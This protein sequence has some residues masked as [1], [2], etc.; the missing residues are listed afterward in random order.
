MVQTKTTLLL[1]LM[2]T[3]CSAIAYHPMQS[4][5]QMCSP[6]TDCVHV[7]GRHFC[8]LKAQAAQAALPEADGM[9]LSNP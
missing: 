9:G 1:S 5:T 8:F 6:G 7:K 2:Y 4:R 3:L